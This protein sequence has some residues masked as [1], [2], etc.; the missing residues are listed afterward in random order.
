MSNTKF[1]RGKWVSVETHD[2][3]DII[4]LDEYDNKLLITSLA[5]QDELGDIPDA[6]HN[7]HLIAAAPD[8]YSDLIDL[9]EAVE[10]M[11]DASDPTTDLY[12]AVNVARVTLDRIREGRN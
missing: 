10:L 7:A 1:S 2:G 5:A 11:E 3:Y 4:S 8:L 12:I 6:E 9:I